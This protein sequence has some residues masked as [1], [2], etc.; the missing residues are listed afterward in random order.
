MCICERGNRTSQ[1][2]RCR[3]RRKPGIYVYVYVYVC[4]YTYVCAYVLVYLCVY[5]S[6]VIVRLNNLV[7]ASVE[8][9]VY[10]YM[11]MYTFVCIRMFV[12]MYLCVSMCICERGNRTFQCDIQCPRCRLMQKPGIY[13]YVHVYVCLYTY[14][15]AYVFVYLKY[16]HM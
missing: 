15:C 7:A 2:S 9:Q 4:L 1:Q 3:L 5:V 11:C 10:T 13:V 6:E 8:N 16:V 14:V 12:H